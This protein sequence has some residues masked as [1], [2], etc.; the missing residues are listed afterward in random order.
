[1]VRGP[2]LP[3]KVEILR[4]EGKMLQP[5]SWK[6]CKAW[7]DEGLPL[8]TTSDEAAKMLHAT[9]WQHLSF[10]NDPALGGAEGTL[11]AVLEA[12]PNCVMG[13]VLKNLGM[14]NFSSKQRPQ[15]PRNIA[16]AEKLLEM[17]CNANEREYMHCKAVLC[18]AQGKM[19]EACNVWERILIKYPRDTLAM[20]Q[21][22]THYIQS[23]KSTEMRDSTNRILPHYDPREISYGFL[24]GL[25]CFSLEECG[26]YAE[27]EL[28]GRQALH[29]NPT[30]GWA[31]H[32]M[33]HIFEMQCRTDEGIQFM[34]STENNWKD[35]DYIA[36]HDY[37]H[38]ALFHV[39][40]G[41]YEEALGIF[42]EKIQPI[43]R[44]RETTFSFQDM[45]ALLY[46]IELE[47][48]SVGDRWG[49]VCKS[50]S[51]RSKDHIYS[52]NDCHMM[53][54][55]LGADDKEK[56]QEFVESMQEYLGG[57]SSAE[58]NHSICSDVTWPLTQAMI[59]F[60]EGKFAECVDILY[61]VRYQVFRI[62]G[63]HAQREFA[64]ML[65]IH[66]AMKSN[67]N[68]H[69]MLAK[70]VDYQHFLFY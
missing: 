28:A 13:L 23:G 66:A 45:S 48:N 31:T 62:G 61:P 29:I 10:R 6:D 52:F 47:G 42:D 34:E 63:S 53:M 57:D 54:A 68:E 4:N 30:N 41:Q 67:L 12:D 3:P 44:Q 21:A 38:W 1:M 26:M 20:L 2:V 9:L 36:H 39:E 70:Y 59:A 51:P 60:K 46:R 37:W 65:L 25:N 40:K 18:M 22:F 49:E 11:E 17:A 55:F 14:N 58:D 7:Y 32:A 69:R 5:L 64:S 33:A 35:S 56:R 27:A 24:L 19:S 8:S 15:I 16:E 50:W 43:A